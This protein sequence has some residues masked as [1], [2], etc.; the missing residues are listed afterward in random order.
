M[1]HQFLGVVASTAV[2]SE[3]LTGWWLPLLCTMNCTGPPDEVVSA[4]GKSGEALSELASLEPAGC[5]GLNMLPYL[6]GERTPQ[7]PHATGAFLGLRPGMLSR[8]GLLYRAAL[9][10]STFSLA[11]GVRLCG[12][13]SCV[14]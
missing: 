2:H 12:I 3:W 7:W 11:D 14:V 10:G 4:F 13:L 9:E 8:P 5:N 6:T 1:C